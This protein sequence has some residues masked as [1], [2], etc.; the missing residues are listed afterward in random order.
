MAGPAVTVSAGGVVSGKIDTSVLKSE[1]RIAGT[2]DVDT[3]ELAGAVDNSTVV[4][5]SQLDLRLSV[6]SGKL[7]IAFGPGGR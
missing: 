6:P 4:R 2:F 5:A 3:A 1:G 7:Q